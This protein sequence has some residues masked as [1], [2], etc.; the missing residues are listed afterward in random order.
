MVKLSRV[1][2]SFP[3]LSIL[4]SNAM[5]HAILTINSVLES[6]PELLCLSSLITFV[7]RIAL[8]SK[9]SS[10]KL[11][12]ISSKFLF[13][14]SVWYLLPICTTY[15]PNY[16][17]ANISTDESV[18]YTHWCI[19]ISYSCRKYYYGTISCRTMLPSFYFGS[20]ASKVVVQTQK[21]HIGQN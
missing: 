19:Q 7:Y 6:D 13:P 3:K 8:V 17:I 18:S 11:P 20:C 2:V 14:F 10:I 12:Q 15:R 1:F 16:R 21:L 5:I 4:C 9:N